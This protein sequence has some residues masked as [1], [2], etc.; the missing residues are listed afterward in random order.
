MQPCLLWLFRPPFIRCEKEKI[1]KEDES[2]STRP[3]GFA[4]GKKV[5]GVTEIFLSWARLVIHSYFEVK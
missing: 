4:A 3:A 2:A 1:K 5:G